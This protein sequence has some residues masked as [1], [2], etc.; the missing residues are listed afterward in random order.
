MYCSRACD[1]SD[2]PPVVVARGFEVISPSESLSISLRYISC[3]HSSTGSV[4]F[5][6][7]AL[8]L[9]LETT[10]PINPRFTNR[11]SVDRGNVHPGWILI[12]HHKVSIHS[13]ADLPYEIASTLP[14]RI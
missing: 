9:R 14:R 1:L 12:Q 2:V 11:Y 6:P 7:G 4:G 10:S 8:H 5:T 13:H 3:A